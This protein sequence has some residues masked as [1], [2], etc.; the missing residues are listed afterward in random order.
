MERIGLDQDALK[1]Q[2]AKQLL[3]HSTFVILACGVA[4]LVDR[5]PKAAKYSVTWAMNA[6]PPPLVGS[7]EPRRVLPSQIN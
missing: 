3:E 4:G 1:I 2:F 7:I 5:Q 6:E